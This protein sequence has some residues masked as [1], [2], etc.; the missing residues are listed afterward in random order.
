M[1]Q[2]GSWKVDWEWN[3]RVAGKWTGNGT[4]GS[5]KVDWEWNSRVVKHCWDA[6]RVCHHNFMQGSLSMQTK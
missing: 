4:A 3:S 2:Q 6:E 5:W 1:E